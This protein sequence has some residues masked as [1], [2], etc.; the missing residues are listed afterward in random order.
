M[1]EMGRSKAEIATALDVP[2]DL[3]RQ[4]E[5]GRKHVTPSELFCLA[6]GREFENA[7]QFGPLIKTYCG[8]G[9]YRQLMQR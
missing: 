2:S 6:H 3:V 5:A 8:A 7:K 1:L 4:W 9:C